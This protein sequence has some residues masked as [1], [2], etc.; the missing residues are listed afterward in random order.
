MLLHNRKQFERHAAGA[1]GSG[2]PFLDG[3]FTG[4]EIAGK[5]G[6]ADAVSFAKLLDLRGHDFGQHG[7]RLIGQLA[8]K[9]PGR[10]RGL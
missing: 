8:I 6:L 7:G 2:F 4:I 5:D 9:L 3:A 10:K 1:L